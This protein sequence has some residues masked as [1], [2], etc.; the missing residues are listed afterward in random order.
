MTQ[1]CGRDVEELISTGSESA[2][3]AYRRGWRIS[4]TQEPQC[5]C[6]TPRYRFWELAMRESLL[7]SLLRNGREDLRQCELSLRW[8]WR[9]WGPLH[10]SLVMWPTRFG[11]HEHASQSD[12]HLLCS[13]NSPMRM[14]T[15]IIFFQKGC[16]KLR[17]PLL[18]WNFSHIYG[19][20]ILT[21]FLSS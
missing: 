11:H 17:L 14:K 10:P 18:T 20:L 12:S 4:E 15:V 19:K 16:Q 8:I 9:G 13:H 1:N 6:R 2:V 5:R 3:R 7:R 21:W